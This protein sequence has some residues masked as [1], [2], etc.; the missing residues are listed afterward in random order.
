[1]SKPRSDASSAAATL[2][3]QRIT[4]DEF[5]AKLSPKDRNNV[6]KHLLAVGSGEAGDRHVATWR[7]LVCSLTTLAPHQVKLGADHSLL[8]FVPDGPYKM[9]VFAMRDARDGNIDVYCG[10]VLEQAI[11][12]KIIRPAPRKPGTATDAA[13][14]EPYRLEGVEEI[15]PIERFDGRIDNL[16]VYSKN[17]VGWNRKAIRIHLTTSA[18]EHQLRT[19]EQLCALTTAKITQPA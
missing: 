8:F 2:P 13:G 9:Q 18:T 4:Y 7:R 6:E 12:D 3:E 16:P 1:M 15:L 11:A 14:A 10:D 17:L 19:A 5:L